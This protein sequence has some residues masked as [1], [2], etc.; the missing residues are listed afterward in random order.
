MRNNNPYT[1]FKS[2]RDRRLALVSRDCRLV[3]IAFICTLGGG[4]VLPHAAKWLQQIAG[5][6]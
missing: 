6:M 5:A 3:V 4:Q 1:A 2:D